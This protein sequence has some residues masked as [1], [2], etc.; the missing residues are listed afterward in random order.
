MMDKVLI[1]KLP[2]SKEILGAKRWEEER[3]EFVQISYKEEM[4]HLAIFEVRKG[5]SR[6]NHYHEKKEEIFYVVKGKIK[7]LLV[8]MDTLQEEEDVFEKGDKIRI[9]PRCG[10][11]FFGL[12]DS[13]IVE[14]SPQ[15]F[16]V[17]D[18]YGID[19]GLKI[20]A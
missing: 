11:L 13:L 4:R 16:D 2:H 8:D 6:G 10:H 15:I 3:G 14:Y 9:K 18:R 7:A 20:L 12:E 5:F 17:E 19:S 1:E